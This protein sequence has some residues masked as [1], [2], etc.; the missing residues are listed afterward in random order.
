LHREQID[1]ILCLQGSEAIYKLG[2]WLN[3]LG[4]KLTVT[5]AEKVDSSV[6]DTA[7]SSELTV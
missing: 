6:A 1:E 2:T 5:V 7:N 3:A 4:L